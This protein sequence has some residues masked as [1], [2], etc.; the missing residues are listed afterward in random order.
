M[1][2]AHSIKMQ[3]W[4]SDTNLGM[5]SRGLG[6]GVKEKR[7]GRCLSSRLVHSQGLEPWTH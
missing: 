3:C 4:V 5:V 6:R 7:G 2:L 1:A